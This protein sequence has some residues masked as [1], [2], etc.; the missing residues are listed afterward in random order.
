[1]KKENIHFH[2][3]DTYADKFGA[4]VTHTMLKM[5]VFVILLVSCQAQ[6]VLRTADYKVNPLLDK[7]SANLLTFR[8]SHSINIM[9]N[10][11]WGGMVDDTLYFVALSA[12]KDT[13]FAFNC[14]SGYLRVLPLG[15]LIN[16]QIIG[17]HTFCYHNHDSIFFCINRGAL[18]KLNKIYNRNDKD[19]LLVNG[20]GELLNRYSLDSLPDIYSGEHS[21][22]LH[23]PWDDNVDERFFAG[24]LL[25]D[26]VTKFP[27]VTESG[28]SELNPKIMALC[29]LVNNGIRMLNIRYPAD[30]QEKKYKWSPGMWV[31]VTGPKEL[32]VGFSVTPYIYR[33]D[34][35]MDTMVKLDVFYNETLRNTDSASMSQ[36]KEYPAIHF[37]KPVW[38]P[39]NAC[40]FRDIYIHH[41]KDYQPSN[42]V[43]MMDSNYN[44]IGYLYA[45]KKQ[46]WQKIRC[47]ADGTVTVADNGGYGRHTVRLTGH[48]RDTRLPVLEKRG[49]SRRQK[50][51]KSSTKLQM[52][53][54]MEKMNLPD[55][56]FALLINM[57]YPCGPCIQDLSLF[58]KE[59]LPLMEKKGVY[60]LFF[61]PEHSDD[62]AVLDVLRNY[63]IRDF[64]NIRIDHKL[65]PKVTRLLPNGKEAQ[66][67]QYIILFRQGD[68]LGYS[69]PDFQES[70][71]TLQR[72]L[73]LKT[74]ETGNQ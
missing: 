58:Y 14:Y 37:G 23:Y 32:L 11:Q 7:A 5:L 26:V 39:A 43:E 71:T 41:Y 53:E 18:A 47:N 67:T 57:K 28:F 49:M 61:D 16:K 74:K 34:L 2:I 22:G 69:L 38:S 73:N 19:I 52:P 59:H 20:K 62:G 17:T 45:D 64:K 51:K 33:Y 50:V 60:Y 36:G 9:S 35:D 1:M 72:M 31:K 27:Y 15:H 42:I 48:L 44:H 25:V 29:N 13:L 66:Y 63:G 6:S 68:Y 8:E 4:S 55:S 3:V 46:G 70:M 54:Y 12:E 24:G 56:C 10:V 30:I 65:L 21:Y 40:F